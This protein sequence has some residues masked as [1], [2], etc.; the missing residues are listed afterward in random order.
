MKKL[1]VFILIGLV[2]FPNSVYASKLHIGDPS[3]D[4][5]PRFFYDEEGNLVT[6]REIQGQALID[7]FTRS[8]SQFG[9]KSLGEMDIELLKNL[10]MNVIRIHIS[11]QSLP[12][13]GCPNACMFWE[14][15]TPVS[16]W[17]DALLNF[18]QKVKNNNLYFT[19]D[20]GLGGS[21]PD[22]WFRWER[23]WYSL[24]WNETV[25]DDFV[26]IWNYTL[27]RIKEAGL[28]DNLVYITPASEYFGQTWEPDAG[29]N[30]YR[31][32]GYSLILNYSWNKTGQEKDETYKYV[33]SKTDVALRS[34]QNWLKNYYK[35]N[36]TALIENWNRYGPEPWN[37]TGNETYDWDSLNFSYSRWGNRKGDF[38]FWM[39]D[40]INN[41]T[42]RF[43]ERIKKYFP[44]VYITWDTA[45]YIGT[46]KCVTN[47][48]DFLAHHFY[49]EPPWA[50]WG[51]KFYS[52]RY[53][54]Y[55][56]PIAGWA[57]ALNKP[58]VNDES[59]G[60]CCQWWSPI[61]YY[62]GGI[63]V[64]SG[65]AMTNS[66]AGLLLFYVGHE[67]FGWVSFDFWNNYLNQ[68]K[69]VAEK[70]MKLW[71]GLERYLDKIEYDKIAIID[72]FTDSES[73]LG[74]F[75]FLRQAG[76]NP[77]YIISSYNNGTL[78]PPEIPLDVEVIV[79]PSGIGDDPYIIMSPEEL[80]AVNKALSRGA[81]A[82][83]SQMVG[84]DFYRNPLRYEDYINSSYF[85]LNPLDYKW[86][87]NSTPIYVNVDGT[88]IT[89]NR[90]AW[91]SSGN[92]VKWN[93]SAI[94][95]V[96]LINTTEGEPFVI[97]NDKIAWIRTPLSTNNF[98]YSSYINEP[99][100]YL[101][102]KKIFE[103]WGIKPVIEVDKNSPKLDT[104]FAR[105][106]NTS[107]VII[108]Y[109][110]HHDNRIINLSINLDKAKLD[111]SYN[112]ILFSVADWYASKSYYSSAELQ[113][114]IPIK[115]EGNRSQAVIIKKYGT[116]T[117][118]FSDST[119][120]NEKYENNKLKLNFSC[121]VNYSSLVA[122]SSPEKPKII[123]IDEVYIP[124]S[125][126]LTVTPSWNYN[127]TNKILMIK[128]SC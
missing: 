29:M 12:A 115:I 113:A 103:Y 70:Y 126:N 114:G 74:N 57:R 119:L 121:S 109:N 81:K 101:I 18:F 6:L 61:E 14:N 60:D 33:K 54:Y 32:D 91:W 25:F 75:A 20:G 128:F 93:T 86:E 83:I 67:F 15:R 19:I 30:P 22:Y 47:S 120:K 89:I 63:N 49:A 10:S 21:D 43:S 123:R 62:T 106:S 90:S 27:T 127:E 110:H 102:Y 84:A 108:Q 50:N 58:M 8:Y 56:E 122:V 94:K 117:F 41:F 7:Y 118:V 80:K 26:W 112:Y 40:V 51:I 97:I 2:V 116:P 46:N 44:E 9:G 53:Q 96:W 38:D 48:S 35:D 28:L 5:N 78:Y 55:W 105:E 82:I 104:T 36:I 52:D 39:N 4:E 13:A 1:L 79:L 34:W 77:E 69:P 17:Y 37:Y 65:L 66:Y 71:K 31:F 73:S 16:E 24:L 92:S 72:S 88:I 45:V 59:G 3:K 98:H 87:R 42:R 95:G 85:P 23:D 99:K 125:E 107:A 11:P 76:F 64:T 111:P 124:Y 68:M 100:T